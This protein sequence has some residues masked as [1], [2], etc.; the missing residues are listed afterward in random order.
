MGHEPAEPDPIRSTSVTLNG[1][2]VSVCHD[3]L[4]TFFRT[5]CDNYSRYPVVIDSGRLEIRLPWRQWLV[6]GIGHLC[7]SLL[8]LVIGRFYL[9]MLL[10]LGDSLEVAHH[11][12]GVLLLFMGLELFTVG[13]NCLLDLGRIR[14]D[15]ASGQLTWP[16]WLGLRRPIPLEQL[17]VVQLIFGGRRIIGGL[18]SGTVDTWQINAIVT[19]PHQPRHVLLERKMLAMEDNECLWQDALLIAQFLGVPLLDGRVG[20]RPTAEGEIPSPTELFLLHPNNRRFLEGERPC[21]R[22]N[23]ARVMVFLKL[24]T[25]LACLLGLFI[26]IGLGFILYESWQ[27]D[28]AVPIQGKIVKKYTKEGHNGAVSYR[29]G[30]RLSIE[31]D[32]SPLREA[33]LSEQEYDQLQVGVAVAALFNPAHPWFSRLAYEVRSDQLQHVVQILGYC[34]LVSGVLLLIWLL[35][36]CRLEAVS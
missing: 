14:F 36:W 34:L 15:L 11:C 27:V 16:R 4:P 10:V 1:Q 20:T 6:H 26:L 31:D 19:D 25:F 32:S 5:Q 28:H 9:I 8:L 29:A 7:G 23:S 24:P 35:R 17:L 13:S 18:G 21:P 30:Y 33:F 22:C 2:T 3:R 12:I